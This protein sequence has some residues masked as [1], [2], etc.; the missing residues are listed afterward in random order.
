MNDASAHI[1]P[2]A[3]SDLPFLWDMLYEAALVAAEIRVLEKRAALALP[4][5][6]RHLNDWGRRGDAG[7]IALAADGSPLGAAW[8]RLYPPAERGYGIVAW[9][10]VP[11]LS[12]G[13]AGA[14][15]G[16]GIGTALLDAL[17]SRAAADGYHQLTLSVDPTNP[18]RR[19]YGR[20][21]FDEVPTANPDLGTSILMVADAAPVD[22]QVLLQKARALATRAH[23][24]QLDKGGHPY[25]DHPRRVAERIRAEGSEAMAV[26]ILHDVMED[27]EVDAETLRRE[28]F[29]APIVRAV[30]S[31]TRHPAEPYDAYIT[32]ITDHAPRVP[33]IVKLADLTDNLDTTRL[34]HPLTP[35]DHTRL[36]RYTTA[37]AIIEAALSRPKA[38]A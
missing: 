38:I 37:K 18:A 34:R 14:H 26:A 17:Q 6:A 27:A 32:R 11:E 33:L 35:S 24:N 23:R 2:V 19:L 3:P 9:P 12:I 10:H 31:I 8:Y 7:V 15:R 1:R 21:G 5:I 20:Q 16:R 25:I 13:V 29:T 22:P 36:K 4:S 30:Q 28:G